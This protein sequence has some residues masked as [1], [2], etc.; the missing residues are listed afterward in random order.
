[1]LDLGAG[2]H[3]IRKLLAVRGFAT[4]QLKPKRQAVPFSDGFCAEPAARM[5]ER[6]IDVPPLNA[7]D[8]G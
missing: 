7:P 8:L 2:F 6:L 4:G 3:E 1:V 5:P